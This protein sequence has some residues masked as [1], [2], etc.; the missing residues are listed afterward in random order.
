MSLSIILKFE[1]IRSLAFGSIV[2]GYTPIGDALDHPATLLTVQNLTNQP[3]MFS[4]DGIKDHFILTA[5]GVYNIDCNA[6]R[7]KEGSSLSIRKGTKLY[8][9]RVGTPTSGSVYITV[10]YQG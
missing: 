4:F 7:S 6:N 2:A 3:L 9:K 8:V 10:G 5:N 1:A